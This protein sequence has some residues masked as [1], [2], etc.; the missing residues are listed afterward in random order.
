[1]NNNRNNLIKN[2]DIEKILQEKV[3][4]NFLL[5]YHIIYYMNIF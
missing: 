4:S 5:S 3:F 1:M 2:G